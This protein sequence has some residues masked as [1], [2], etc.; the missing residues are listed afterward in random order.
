[1]PFVVVSRKAEK[2]IARRHPWI[3]SGAVQ[4]VHG[5]LSNGDNVAV[6]SVDGR[7]LGW[8]AFSAQ[9]QIRVRLWSFDEQERPD[10][11]LLHLRLQKALARRQALPLIRNATAWRL[12]NAESDG[13]PGLIVDHYAGFLVCQFLS[14]GVDRWRPTI[15]EH[16]RHL[17]PVT[18]I[19]ERSDASVRNKEGLPQRKGCLWGR[20]PPE[21]VEMTFGDIRLWAD[22]VNG[23]KTGFYLDQRENHAVVGDYAKAADMLNCFSYTG[24]FCVQALAAGAACVTN[25]D[26]SQAALDLTERNI[27]HNGFQTGNANQVVGN[28]FEIMRCMRDRGRLFDLIVLDPPKFVPSAGRMKQGARGYKDINLLAFKLLKPGGVLLTFSCSGLVSA[29]LFQKIVSDAALDA[30]CRAVVLKKLSQAP[31]HP[32]ALTFPE[33]SYLKGL[34]CQIEP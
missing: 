1:M 25:L 10:A 4:K 17:L 19:Y 26:A 32:V 24:T 23:H 3:F 33:G 28:A 34:V 16:L 5:T 14:A 13:L 31:D 21:L 11:D 27:A 30:G 6:R 20:K 22:L 8:G 12:V 2:S 15:T 7:F 29:D 18:G 9:S